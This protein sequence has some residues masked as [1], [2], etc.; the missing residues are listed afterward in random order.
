MDSTAAIC[1]NSQCP[2]ARH[3]LCQ[4]ENIGQRPL[5]GWLMIQAMAAVSMSC[6]EIVY[7]HFDTYNY[8]HQDCTVSIWE[9]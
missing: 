1:L 2:F 5:I 3:D 9:T 4:I 6:R 8:I 7:G